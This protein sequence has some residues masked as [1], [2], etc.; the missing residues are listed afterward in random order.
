MMDREEIITI[1]EQSGILITVRVSV[2]R[3]SVAQLPSQLRR[4]ANLNRSGFCGR[5]MGL[6]S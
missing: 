3:D 6:K 2:Q 1:L 5:A 4:L